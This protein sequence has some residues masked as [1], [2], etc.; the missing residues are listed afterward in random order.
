MANPGAQ[1]R[2]ILAHRK[3]ETLRS[4]AM[5]AQHVTQLRFVSLNPATQITVF[6]GA[7]IFMQDTHN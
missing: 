2:S 7:E 6:L 4:A 5:P 3:S 1:F